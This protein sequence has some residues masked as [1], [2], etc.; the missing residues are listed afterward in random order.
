MVHTFQLTSQD[1]SLAWGHLVEWSKSRTGPR[2][3]SQ[4][5]ALW[6]MSFASSLRQ[7]VLAKKGD[8]VYQYLPKRALVATI[9][10]HQTARDATA[11]IFK[12]PSRQQLRRQYQKKEQD[13]ED[14][15]QEAIVTLLESLPK[16]KKGEAATLYSYFFGVMKNVARSWDRRQ[17]R[18]PQVVQQE[19]EWDNLMRAQEKRT[20]NEDE[21]FGDVVAQCN[22]IIARYFEFENEGQLVEQLLAQTQDNYREVIELRYLEGMSYEEISQQLS[23]SEQNARSKVSRGIAQLRKLLEL[24]QQ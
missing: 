3:L 7:K 18:Q 16:D 1:W 4:P 13:F 6:L 20:P 24:H 15:Y 21:D 14:I 8:Y 11:L 2:T 9:P 19:E 10:E 17:R 12:E 23:I 5:L 22:A